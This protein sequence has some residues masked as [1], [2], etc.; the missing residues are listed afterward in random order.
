M[1]RFLVRFVFPHSG[2]SPALGHRVNVRAEVPQHYHPD[3]I[4]EFPM[5]DNP[6]RYYR[7]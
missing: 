2:S 3:Y 1:A 5:G 4:L 6:Y 7:W